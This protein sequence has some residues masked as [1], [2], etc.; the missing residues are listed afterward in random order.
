[1]TTVDDAVKTDITYNSINRQFTIKKIAKDV[2]GEGKDG[3]FKRTVNILNR[4]G[5]TALNKPATLTVYIYNPDCASATMTFNP[6]KITRT[7]FT[8]AA[9]AATKITIPTRTMSKATCYTMLKTPV[10][11]LATPSDATISVSGSTLS[12]QLSGSVKTANIGIHK[13][14]LQY[15]HPD[16]A[17]PTSVTNGLI[18]APVAISSSD[19]ESTKIFTTTGSTDG[20]L[21]SFDHKVG[22]DSAD[23]SALQF[24]AWKALK[25]SSKCV[26]DY[27]VKTKPTNIADTYITYDGDNRKV[28]LKKITDVTKTGL[29]DVI[30]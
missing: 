16:K 3:V 2:T 4:T 13:I 14:T 22:A 7:S 18:Y 30:W 20:A 21:K 12:Y 5:G 11:D 28:T 10:M 23:G 29:H 9:G 25:A 24:S 17:A 1:M 15:Q 26:V 8:Y 27:S 6:T 19:C